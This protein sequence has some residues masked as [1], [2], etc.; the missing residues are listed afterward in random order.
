[1]RS[2]TTHLSCA[3]MVATPLIQG[4][5]WVWSG[6]NEAA[7]DAAMSGAASVM[8][9]ATS[10]QFGSQLPGHTFR[11]P[12]ASLLG[13]RWQGAGGHAPFP[14]WLKT[15]P[16][17]FQSPS[18][19]CAGAQGPSGWFQGRWSVPRLSWPNTGHHWDNGEGALSY[20]A[21]EDLSWGV[22]GHGRKLNP[23]INPCLLLLPFSPFTSLFA[24]FPK[25]YLSAIH[26]FA[27]CLYPISSTSILV[28]C[29]P[30][31]FKMR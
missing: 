6:C 30:L 25:S 8:P 15:H 18:S 26:L 1:M 4:R 2:A 27:F 23:L 16:E 29:R 12:A 21:V 9:S 19:L 14:T 24:V 20:Q 3:V 10:S 7:S 11:F 28:L 31:W 13:M 22:G 5:A 17:C